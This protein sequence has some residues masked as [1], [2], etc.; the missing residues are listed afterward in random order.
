[1]KTRLGVLGGTF[2]PIHAGHLYVADFLADYLNL[3]RVIFIP[4]GN[5][6]HKEIPLSSAKHRLKMVQLAIDEKPKFLLSRIE[7]FKREKTYTIDTIRKLKNK[8]NNAEIYFIIGADNITEIP[9]WK[10]YKKLL[11]E[12]QMVAIARPGYKLEKSLN[13][14]KNKLLLIN[15]SSLNISST[16]IRAMIEKGLSVKNL[17]P[18]LIKKY[19]KKNKLYLKNE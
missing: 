1:M 6:P 17:V 8:Y 9:T 2:D 18:S 7:I 4:C 15:A 11:N 14:P 10:N 5:P 3:N 19:I 12:C 13:I 16:K